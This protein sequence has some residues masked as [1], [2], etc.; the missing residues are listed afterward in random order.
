MKKSILLLLLFSP[1]LILAQISLSKKVYNLA[2]PNDGEGLAQTQLKNNATDPND[3]VFIWTVITYT[4]D[5]AWTLSFCDPYNCIPESRL[6]SSMSFTLSPGDS[7]VMK[8]DVFYNNASGSGT[9]AV[10]IKSALNPAHNDTFTIHATAWLTSVKKATKPK[11]NLVVYPNPAKDLI[12]ID[13]PS[14]GNATIEVYNVLGSKVKTYN[15][16]NGAV[17]KI[18]IADLQKGVYFIRVNDKNTVLT[19]QIQKLN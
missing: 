8:G 15:H 13:I 11:S 14:K 9:A 1:M 2:G 4:F 7:G 18:D 16:E 6:D 19:K 3:S 5:Q 10:V 12:T 17:A